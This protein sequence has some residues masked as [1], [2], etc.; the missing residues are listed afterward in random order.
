VTT[1]SFSTTFAELA[2][3]CRRMRP[4]AA[5]VLGS[6]SDLVA[7]RV[8]IVSSLPF[9]DIPGLGATTVAGHRGR[10][11]LG[12]WAGKRVLVFEGRLHFYEGHPWSRV[13][14]PARIA[15]ELGAPVLLVTNAAGGISDALVPGCLMA[16]RD[17]IEWNRPRCWLHAG[18]GALGP[19]R[20]SPYAPRLCQLLTSSAGQLGI[21]LIQGVYASLTGPCYET[22]AEIR[23]LRIWGADAVGMSTAREV[24]LA[25]ELGL[26]C[27]ALSCITNKAAGLSAERLDH[28]KVLAIAAAQ[29]QRLTGILEGFLRML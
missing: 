6:G 13:V 5:V 8:H 7:D 29:T 15:H 23:T 2:H 21:D 12:D 24:Q 17:H 25:W 26:E 10:L 27:A 11:T 1:S 3:A 18:P 16:I 14:E 4:A 28:K 22:P 20:P 9:G 19:P